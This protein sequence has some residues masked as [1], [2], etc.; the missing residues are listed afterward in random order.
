MLL[1]QNRRVWLDWLLGALMTAALFAALSL[2]TDF[3]YEN[4]DDGLILRTFMGFEGGV[5]ADFSLYIHTA[6]AWLLFGFSLVKPGMPWFS[7][8]QLGLLLFSCVVLCKCMS[9]LAR[10]NRSPRL[11]GVVAGALYLALFAAFACCRV[12]YTTTAAL[13]GAAAVA[14]YCT[15]DG[16]GEARGH[17]RA[18]AF[19]LCLLLLAAAYCLRA[20]SA[21]PSVAF[22]ALAFVWRLARPGEGVDGAVNRRKP[23]LRSFLILCVAL[24]ALAGVRTLEVQ[25][26]GLQPEV[27]WHAARTSLMD[28]TAF[29]EEPA[30]ALA[31]DSGLLP[32]EVELVRQWYFLDG[33]LTAPVLTRLADAYPQ[34]SP[35]PVG[36]LAA[37]VGENPRYG[38]TLLAL[39]ALCGLC[40]I[41]E[42]KRAPWVGL[43]AVAALLGA[44][45]LMALL[46][47]RGRLLMR[48]ADAAL[49]PC[50]ALLACL[51]LRKGFPGRDARLPRRIAFI[52]LALLLFGSVA[53]NARLTFHAVTRA[54]DTVSMQREADLE[55]YAL[56]NPETLVVRSPNLLRDTRLNPDVSGGVPGNILL[57][58]DWT[59]HTPSWNRQLAAYGFDAAAF[60][61]ADWLKP[62]IL[63]AAAEA[64]DTDDLRAYLTD[65]LGVQVTAVAVAQEGTLQYYRFLASAPLNGASAEA[66]TPGTARECVPIG[67]NR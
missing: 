11:A 8:F 18:R 47:W 1:M 14:Q 51:A 61:P 55:S 7:L 16:Y 40:L 28:F 30:L 19:T 59:C 32:A 25:V 27:D 57:W 66:C 36:A 22:I 29:Q 62:N 52:L 63:L 5:P 56:N 50:G 17:A 46:G 9:S 44:L 6:L 64:S 41:G 35:N 13:A 60:S 10:A 2:V 53:L 3:R 48:A 58:G 4:S 24:A 33:T 15:L 67:A 21:W 65:A 23:I 20:Q 38:Y 42:R 49:L 31:A 26:R 34:A 39:L 37:F 54:P 45:L 43:V 12:N